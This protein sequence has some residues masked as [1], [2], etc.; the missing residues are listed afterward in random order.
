[1]RDSGYVLIPY[2]PR[3][4]QYECVLDLEP[5]TFAEA[6]SRL[7]AA[8]RYRRIAEEMSDPGARSALIETAAELER[9]VSTALLLETAIHN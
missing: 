6:L 9:A 7:A 2:E 5:L 1:M 4:V 3:K 8:E